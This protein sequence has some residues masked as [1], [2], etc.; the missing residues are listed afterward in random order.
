MPT[1]LTTKCLP[2]AGAATASGGARAHTPQRRAVAAS[3]PAAPCLAHA[4]DRLNDGAP[5]DA[6]AAASGKL[7]SCGRP[8]VLHVDTD[9]AAAGVL[10]TL[11]VPEAHVTHAATLAQARKLLESDVFSLVVL[12]PVLPDGDAR[13]LLPLLGGTPLLVYSAN[14]PEWRGNAPV[15]L[16]KPWTSARQLWSA[17][18]SLLGVPA[19]LTAGD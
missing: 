17:I 10:A 19:T 6:P 11:V 12:D 5:M 7:A 15:F 18:S 14:Q 16:P 13:T 8:R 9:L 1:T 3:L 4:N 2:R